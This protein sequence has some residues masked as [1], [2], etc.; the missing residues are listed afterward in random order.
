MRLK[1]V[2]LKVDIEVFRQLVL[3]YK[4]VQIVGDQIRH[5]YLQNVDATIRKLEGIELGLQDLI[6]AVL[7]IEKL[8]DNRLEN[9]LDLRHR[10][11]SE[12]A[13]AINLV[14]KLLKDPAMT[15]ESLK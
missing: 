11:F 13:D 8:E 15:I 6:T 2:L 10:L 7:M 12:N 1:F 4:D 3:E 14:E 9:G 5:R